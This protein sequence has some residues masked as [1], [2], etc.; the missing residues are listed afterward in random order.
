MARSSVPPRGSARFRS[1]PR[2]HGPNRRRR[3]R[4][5]GPRLRETGNMNQASDRSPRRS[6]SPPD[7]W[8]R[9]QGLAP[10]SRKTAQHGL[11][12]CPTPGS[13]APWSMLSV[14]GADSLRG[15][16][17]RTRAAAS[18]T[19][20][21]RRA[22]AAPATT[23]AR[24]ARSGWRRGTRSTWSGGYGP[25]HDPLGGALPTSGDPARWGAQWGGWRAGTIDPSCDPDPLPLAP[26]P[27]LPAAFAQVAGKGKIARALRAFVCRAVRGKGT[28]GTT[29]R[30]APRPRKGAER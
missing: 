16:D 15:N 7:G 25:C 19:T 11:E 12:A 9:R 6:A 30:E 4:R 23:A 13:V 1:A 21:C 24:S 22:S 14:G 10:T 29:G 20:T 2:T 28:N 3:R 17:V 18:T 27:P 5:P 8:D 26:G